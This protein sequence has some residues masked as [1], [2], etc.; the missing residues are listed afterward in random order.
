MSLVVLTEENSIS[1]V[2]NLVESKKIID[3]YSG[4]NKIYVS[5]DEQRVDRNRKIAEVVFGQCEMLAVDLSHDLE[6][7]SSEI[8]EEK[9][10]LALKISLWALQNK[11]NYD[12]LHELYQQKYEHLRQFPDELRKQKEIEWWKEKLTDNPNLL[13]RN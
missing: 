7:E 6:K 3:E 2:E 5:T 4:I 10:K 11:E 1:S 13:N 8:V 12:K 9:E